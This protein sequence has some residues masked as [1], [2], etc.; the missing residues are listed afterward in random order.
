MEAQWVKNQP[1]IHEDEG[2]I[3]GLAQ[4]MKD[5]GLLWIRWQTRLGSGVAVAVVSAGSCSSDST[6]SL[7]TS[8][9]HSVTLKR[10]KKINCHRQEKASR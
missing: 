1:R 6:P 2:S 4:W 9:G 7:G 10:K 3:P 8:T 5:P